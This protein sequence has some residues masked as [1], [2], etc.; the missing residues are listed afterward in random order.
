[1]KKYNESEII[2]QLG[3]K[4]DIR[5]IGRKIMHLKSGKGDVGIKSK[6][7]MDFLIKYCGYIYVSVKEF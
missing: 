4:N 3:K 7:K 6:G 1:M 2:A 5:I